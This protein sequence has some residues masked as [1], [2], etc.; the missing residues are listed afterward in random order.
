[1]NDKCHK[2][3]AII[4][5]GMA[6]LLAAIN[7]KKANREFMVFEKADS[8]G[9]HGGTTVIPGLPA[10]CQPMLIH[11]ASRPMPNGMLITR[12]VQKLSAI[13]RKSLAIMASPQFIHFNTEITACHF[14]EASNNWELTD[15]HGENHIFDI[16]IVASGVLH[17]PSTP[18]ITGLD[19]F[20]GSCFH[21]AQ[22]ED[23]LVLENNNIGI[24]G[25]GSS[26]IQIATA[27]TSVANQLVHF[28]RS[29]QWIMPVE[30][31]N[32]TEEEKQAFRDNQQLIDDIRYDKQYWD[33]IYRFNKGIINP[34]SPEMQMIE[35]ICRD[36]LEASIQDPALREKLRPDYRAACKR[37]IYNWQYYDCV[38]NQ[39][40]FVETG[41]IDRVMD[42]GVQMQDGTFHT[43]DILVLATGFHADRFIK[44]TSVIGRNGLSLDT[45]WT[46]R[47]TAHYAVTLPG[48]PNMFMLNG[49]TGP[50][51]NFSLIDIAERQWEYIDQLLSI[52]HSGDAE[53]VEPKISAFED[54]EKR[55]IEAA[56][57][58]I[59]SSGCSS[60]YLD[61]T[62]IPMTWPW[63]YQDFADAMQQPILSEYD[64]RGAS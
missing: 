23:D 36:Y 12:R 9:G 15:A 41:S 33:N 18:D 44:P 29:P 58:T 37:L 63:S 40:V 20:Q 8:L 43:L 54:Y 22:W 25:C 48:F 14:Q 30:Q 21:S 2:R 61:M 7:L 45:F 13:L 5:A 62:G 4:G 46:P 57:K 60:W 56:Q 16:V 6:G 27:L 42:S 49:P 64:I 51:G 34:D 52:I 3:T 19:D 59:F 35:D 10:M 26:G 1:M 39:N 32:Y 47:P 11:I 24:I 55:R 50:V 53:T 31:F 17:H 38:Q 28:Q